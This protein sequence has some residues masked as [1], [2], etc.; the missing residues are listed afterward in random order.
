MRV[1]ACSALL[2]R[3][4]QPSSSS[5]PVSFF[6]TSGAA[7]SPPRPTLTST[8]G[9]FAAGA[10]ALAA[11][12]AAFGWVYQRK[13]D[14]RDW[15]VLARLAPGRFLKVPALVAL[16]PTPPSPSHHSSVS[17]SRS[18]DTGSSAEK[19][20]THDPSQRCAPRHAHVVLRGSGYPLVVLEASTGGLTQDFAKCVDEIAKFT[21]VLAY[22][23]YGL[24]FSSE[25]S[26]D[27]DVETPVELQCRNAKQLRIE[28]DEVL[29]CIPAP[30]DQSTSQNTSSGT[31]SDQSNGINSVI[32]VAHGQGGAIAV[33]F[34][35]DC[36]AR[37]SER[38]A[39]VV[40]LESA[41]GVREKQRGIA[42]E[43][44]AAIDGMT[45]GAQAVGLLS[46]FGVARVMM[47]TQKSID[48]LSLSYRPQDCG[49]VQALTSRTN[50]CEGV[51]AEVACYADDD[52]ILGSLV[53]SCKT[54]RGPL[55]VGDRGPGAFRALVVSHGD[56]EMFREL[57]M[58]GGVAIE[59]AQNRLDTL[60]DTWQRGQTDLAAALSRSSVH[61]QA[62]GCGHEMPQRHPEMVVDAVRAMVDAVRS[63]SETA[64]L[65]F[66]SKYHDE[67]G[68]RGTTSFYQKSSS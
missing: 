50:H 55:A 2:R 25:Q 4:R 42:K 41:C 19:G 5:S 46:K 24:G 60:E 16:A 6:S 67:R 7:A 3:A 51:A 45:K 9:Y 26:V 34:A 11:P 66:R 33:D 68:S 1:Q 38:L 17:S 40:L 8:L 28:L 54:S 13:A 61:V 53:E 10:I 47:N 63:D 31:N 49:V 56:A 14:D 52:S 12:L 43:I 57:A 32:I 22:D 59:A 20:S 35:A 48:A 65:D 44:A 36:A 64:L 18:R 30:Q 29:N 15:P 23:R 62:R 37:R 58:Q 39:G 27:A 21:T